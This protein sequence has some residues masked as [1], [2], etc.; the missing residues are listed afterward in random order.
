[1]VFV[2][3]W[4]NVINIGDIVRPFVIFA[5]SRV[6]LTVKQVYFLGK[7]TAINLR[8]IALMAKNNYTLSTGD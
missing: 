8:F 7:I 2:W 3:K 1:M 6:K 4:I 5:S